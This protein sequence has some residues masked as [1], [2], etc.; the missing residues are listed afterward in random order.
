MFSNANEVLRAARG[1]AD[2]A[3]VIF[4]SVLKPGAK[5]SMPD[6]RWDN[7]PTRW[8]APQLVLNRARAIRHE[9][10]RI[11]RDMT[12]AEQEMHIRKLCE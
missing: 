2:E 3:L 1:V 8:D 12:P 5:A 7:N 6:T 11:G 4:Q 9:E 10:I